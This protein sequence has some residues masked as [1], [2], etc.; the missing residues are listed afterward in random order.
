MRLELTFKI[1]NP[2]LPLDN[3]KLWIS[4]LK[5]CLSQCHEG[6]FFERYFGGHQIKDYTY[7]VIFSSPRFQKDKIVLEND[8][9][10]MLFSSDDKHKTGLIFYQAFIGGKQ[11]RFPLP[12]GNGIVLKQITQKREKLIMS[13]KSVFRTVVG[14]GL[15]VR[16]H[17]K[18]NNKDRFLTFQDEGFEKGLCQTLEMQAKE[19][20]FPEGT[21]ERVKFK[22]IKCKKILVKHYYRYVDATCGIFQ[23][24]G[25]PDFLQ[26]LY[27]AGMGAKH[28]AGFGLLDVISQE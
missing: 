17:N 10:K 25:D 23:L 28:S 12:E 13:S 16:E 19:G 21:G 27:Q 26:Y 4:F 24:E 3:S 14:G 1:E 9:I 7:A 15:V 20:G 11:K 8:Q 5:N 6:I 22:A 18:E 2:E